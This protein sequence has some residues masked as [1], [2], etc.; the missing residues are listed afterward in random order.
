MPQRLKPHW[1]KVWGI[2][3]T[4]PLLKL[5][6]FSI[7]LA[8][9]HDAMHVLLEG[10]MGYAIGLLLQVCLTDKIFSLEWLTTQLQAFPYSYLDRDNKPEK[11]NKKQVFESVSI[12]QTAAAQLTLCYVLPFIL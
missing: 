8:M 11:I 5:Q 10:L 2:N 1:S 12:K 6:Y 3:G 9:P 4:S 7:S